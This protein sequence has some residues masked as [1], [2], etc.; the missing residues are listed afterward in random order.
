VESGRQVPKRDDRDQ[1]ED[2]YVTVVLGRVDPLLSYGLQ[3]LLTATGH[4]LILH[5]CLEDAAIERVVVEQAPRVVIL[6]ETAGHDLLACL[7]SHQPSLGVLVLVHRP[8]PVIGTTLVAI[9]ATCVARNASLADIVTAVQL[10]AKGEPLFFSGNGDQLARNGDQL[11]RS[12]P[13]VAGV[14]TK[15]ETET[16]ELLRLG[17]SYAR[18]GRALQVSPETARTHTISICRKLSVKGKQRLIGVSLSTR[19]EP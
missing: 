14:L 3:N 12:G 10:A 6:D 7:K 11:A 2:G 1:S 17:W 4:F 13:T 8:P 19:L 9:G 15:R 5:D 16:F 18:I